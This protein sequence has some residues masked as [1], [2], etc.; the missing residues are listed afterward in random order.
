MMK[1]NLRYLN[2]IV[3]HDGIAYRVC[4]KNFLC[5]I[6][7]DS[8]KNSFWNQ[9]KVL[10]FLVSKHEQRE[11]FKSPVMLYTH[12]CARIFSPPSFVPYCVSIV[13][14]CR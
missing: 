3:R 13:S 10:S 14:E 11:I 4:D 1:W 12:N 5:C 2:D 6:D 7:H 9:N 8:H